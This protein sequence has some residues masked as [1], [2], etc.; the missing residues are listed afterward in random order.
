[1]AGRPWTP[2][3]RSFQ[4]DMVSF[5]DEHHDRHLLVR[6]KGAQTQVQVVVGDAEADM[7]AKAPA[8]AAVKRTQR[9]DANRY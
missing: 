8:K 1:M 4:V 9:E 6:V 7:F 3:D 2:T 5:R